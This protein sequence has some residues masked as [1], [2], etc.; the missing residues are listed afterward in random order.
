ML[1]SS[2]TSL[3]TISCRPMQIQVS[4]RL[5]AEMAVHKLTMRIDEDMRVDNMHALGI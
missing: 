5:C 1:L 2:E 3:K 4:R